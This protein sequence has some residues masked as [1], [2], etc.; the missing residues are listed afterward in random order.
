MLFV[1]PTLLSG[2]GQ[3]VKKYQCLYPDSKYIALCQHTKSDK[4]S[5]TELKTYDDIIK[6]ITTVEIVNWFD[7]NPHISALL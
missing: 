2:I 7:L 1:G 6:Q 5:E 4:Y 3:V